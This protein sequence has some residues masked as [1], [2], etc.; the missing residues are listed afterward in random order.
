MLV[1]F[2]VVAYNAGER[3]NDLIKNINEQDYDH[4]NIEIILVDGNSIDDTKKIMEDF[5]ESD[6]NF[7]RICV[8]DN[9]K[10]TLPCGWNVALD[11][12]KGEIIIRVDAHV[13]IPEDFIANNVA[14][15][16]SG[17][18]ICGGQVISIIDSD[19]NWQRTLLLSENSA[20]GGGIASFRRASVRRYVDTI[21][22]AAYKREVFE[23]VGA[24][25]ERLTRTEDNEIHYR[26]KQ[27]GY[28]FLMDS[29]IHSLRYARN[30]FKKMI[31]Q[32]FGNGYWIGLTMG[33]SPK[34]FSLY[35]FVPFLFVL[36][37]IITSII[38]IYGYSL[39]AY[40]LW[41]AYFIGS[42]GMSVLSI[43]KEKFCFEFLVLPFLFL[44][45][46][47]SYGIGT[48]IGLIKMPFWIRKAQMF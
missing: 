41:G 46:H 18:K 23:V 33:I 7:A 47:I 14:C 2:I 22:F 12:S 20:F 31:K 37:I 48:L 10:R 29:K 19:D 32:K 25:D 11:E 26:M 39:P 27:A 30:T 28:K 21:A 6:H 24:Y 35:H 16:K 43:A 15:I 4:K 45:I 17:E 34:C 1:S 36:A 38:S 9:P 3:L 40:I 8:L 44:I 42:I 5:A 13:S